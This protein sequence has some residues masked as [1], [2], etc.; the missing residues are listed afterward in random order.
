MDAEGYFYFVDRKKDAIRRRGENISSF[1]VE[2][3][4]VAFPAVREAAAYAVPSELGEDEVMIAVAPVEGHAI[5]PRALF[6][7]LREHMA[8][9]MVPRYLRVIPA[10]PKTASAKVQK[11]LLR[12]EGLSVAPLRPSNCGFDVDW[13][14]VLKSFAGAPLGP[15]TLTGAGRSQRGECVITEYGIEGGAIYALSAGLRDAIERDGASEL[16]VDLRPDVSL[17]ALAARLGRPRG[18]QSMASVLR[19]SGGLTPIAAALAREAGPL[20]AD[21]ADLA[22]R[23]KALPLRLVGVRP[24]ARAISSAGGLRFDDVTE[25][26]MVRSRPGLFVAGEMLDWEAP[27]GGYLL[28][29]CFASGR[30]AGEAAARAVK[31]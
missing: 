29:A 8:H 20:P 14:P 21:P 27:T 17:E 3:E 31:V 25:D 23:I 12:A 18:G 10:L 28:Q 1:E 11:H 7:F 24:I 15:V 9:F 6:E 26:L 16:V 13:S 2:A 4:V 30:R 5:E 22:A 19:K